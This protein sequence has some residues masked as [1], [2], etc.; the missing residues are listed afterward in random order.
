MRIYL[1]GATGFI[2]SYVIRALLAAGHVVRCLLR[3]TSTTLVPDDPRVERAEGDVTRPD[4]LRGTMHGC[5]AVIHL[6]GIIDEKPSK[7]V[8]FEAIHSEGTRHVV[9]EA[10]REGIRTFLHMSANGADPDARSGYQRTKWAAEQHVRGGGFGHWTIFRPS[11][12]FGDPGPDRVEFASRL[13]K[14]LI[15]PFPLLPVFGDGMYR[16]QPVSVEDVASAFVQALERPSTAGK[17]YCV[18]GPDELTYRDVL[19]VIAEGAG[20]TPRPKL[21][22]PLW[23]IRP[24]VKAAGSV[25]PISSDQLEMLIGGNVCA[26]DSFARDFDV[27]GRRFTPKNLSYLRG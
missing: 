1:T 15:R 20:L 23:L 6:V 10:R 16:L 19:D 22:Q 11:I 27:S 4:S 9:E 18:G 2:G 7:G 5:E 14:Q 13:L 24:V 3:D 25:L 26:D 12:I 21:P 17:V 8:T